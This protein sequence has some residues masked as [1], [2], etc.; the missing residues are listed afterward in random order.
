MDK[1]KLI[2]ELK[3]NPFAE[4]SKEFDRILMKPIN[5]YT[6]EERKRYYE[7]YEFL[8]T[9]SSIVAYDVNIFQLMNAKF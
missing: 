9:N 4:K 3:S 1:E 6:L 7:L 2:K 8:H 5:N